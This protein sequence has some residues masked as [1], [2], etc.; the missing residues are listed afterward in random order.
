MR[1]WKNEWEWGVYLGG[2]GEGWRGCS[3]SPMERGG[4]SFWYTT[5]KPPP[6]QTPQTHNI[7]LP[8]SRFEMAPLFPLSSTPMGTFHLSPFTF[9][10]LSSYHRQSLPHFPPLSDPLPFTNP[11]GFSPAMGGF[12]FALP[13]GKGMGVGNGGFLLPVHRIPEEIGIGQNPLYQ[14]Y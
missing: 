13:L 8:F 2:V 6:Q 14:L 1:G 5:S 4:F 3:N 11:T 9:H 12:S 7:P 10:L